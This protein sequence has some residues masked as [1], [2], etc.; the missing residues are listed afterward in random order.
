MHKAVVAP[1]EAERPRKIVPTHLRERNHI[2]EQIDVPDMANLSAHDSL[3]EV[4]RTYAS[5]GNSKSSPDA[6]HPRRRRL[7]SAAGIRRT[8][9]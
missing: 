3:E 9:L 8:H 7:G 5:R 6:E 2:D 1:L 4:S